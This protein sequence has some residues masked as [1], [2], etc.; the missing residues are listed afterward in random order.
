M[1]MVLGRRHIILASLVVALA[2][3]IFLNYKF[4]GT[5]LATSA[6][7][8]TSNLGDAAYVSNQNVSSTNKSDFFAT[9]RL[10]RE[11][12]RDTAEQ[13]LKTVTANAQATAAERQK[14]MDTID[15]MAQDVKTEGDIETAV[16]AKGFPE[17]VCMIDDG[18]CSVIVKPK[19]STSLSANDSAQ[20]YDIVI[21]KTK[22][23]QTSITIIPQN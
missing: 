1:S 6:N 20:I 12:N 21:S 8:T 11:Q 22:L 2:L 14:A 19:T 7:T 10:T 4:S 23:A 18:A 13:M 16:E 3:A 5:G 9:A 15:Q 17:C